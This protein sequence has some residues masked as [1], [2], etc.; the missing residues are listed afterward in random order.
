MKFIR[1]QKVKV[2]DLIG[3]S[4]LVISTYIEMNTKTELDMVCFGVNEKD[5]IA[6][7]RYFIFYNQLCAPEGSIQKIKEIGSENSRFLIDFSKLPS[8]IKKIVVA[9]A[10]DGELCMSHMKQGSF[11]LLE[12]N[13][14]IGKFTFEGTDYQAEKA[15][16]LVE[17][18]EKDG[19]WRINF[20][21]RGFN[22]G[23]STLLKSYGGEENEANGV[24]EVKKQVAQN[25]PP[26]SRVSLSKIEEVQ[27][28]VLEKSPYLIDLAKKAAVSLEKKGLLEEVA[29]VA[30]VI[31][32][33]GSMNHQY[34]NGDVQKIFDRILPLALMFDDDKE[35][36]VWTFADEY[37]R[38]T[39]I[40][41]DNIKDYVET[42]AGGWRKWNVGGCNN[43]VSVLRDVIHTYQESRVPAYVIFISDG[44][45]R[46]SAKIKQMI[47]EASVYP[48][49]WQF[50]GIGG[51]NYGVLEKLDTLAN[52]LVDNAN[53][54]SL[55]RIDQMSDETL[56]NQ[57]LNEFPMWLK[58]AKQKKIVQ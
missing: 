18:Y 2:A 32:K 13:R 21:G 25:K 14:E 40:T 44:G 3:D 15:L 19:V 23:L 33:S 58:V 54:F 41:V 24:N 51:K 22:G 27:K 35:L 31:D 56:Y 34:K 42:E 49:F 10:V 47:I 8:T 57:L 39:S 12:E 50:L 17:I 48:I 30:L 4:R 52:R 6:D 55:D 45:V 16:I 46:N 37:R 11:S 26:T 5:Q 9:V 1:G 38:L 53:F 28:I 36:D 29:R 7:D 20:I 43:E